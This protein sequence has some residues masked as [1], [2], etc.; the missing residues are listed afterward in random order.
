MWNPRLIQKLSDASKTWDIFLFPFCHL[1]CDGDVP[2]WSHNSCHSTKHQV[3]IQPRSNIKNYKSFYREKIF[4]K[5]PIRLLGHLATSHKTPG[6]INV[7]PWLAWTK[8]DSPPE[9]S[10][11]SPKSNSWTNS[12]PAGPGEGGRLV[13]SKPPVSAQGRSRPWLSLQASAGKTSN[14]KQH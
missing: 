2:S 3:F 7:M 9:T 10:P 8:F 4:P 12:G 13:C 5:I 11:P 1:Q 14:C 6:N